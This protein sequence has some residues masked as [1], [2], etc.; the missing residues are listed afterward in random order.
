MSGKSQKSGAPQLALA[1]FSSLVLS[2]ALFLVPV[3][4][5]HAQSTVNRAPSFDA[6]QTTIT[7]VENTP[8]GTAVGAPVAATDPDGD[9]LYFALTNG[10]TDL[11]SI[12]SG[13]GQLRTT[14]PLDYETRP[15]DGYWVHVGVRDGRG[16]D[17]SRDLVADDVGLV[18]VEVQNVDEPGTVTL[19][20]KKPQIGAPL[21]ATL[22]DQD[23]E[24]SGL[25]WQWA[26]SASSGAYTD[27]NGATS[28]TYTPVAGNVNRHLRV[29][30][31]YADP[32]GSGKTAQT[33]TGPVLPAP[34][35]DNAPVFSEGDS[36][37][38]SVT[39]NTPPNSNVGSPVKATNTDNQELRY[40]LD[41]E[42]F[43]IDSRTG[44]IKTKTSP[45][46]ET[47]QS[48]TVQV[49]VTDPFA[50]SDSISVTINVIDQPVEIVGPSNV[51]YSEDPYSIAAPV[52]QYT[53]E[54]SSA[55]LT[56]TGPDAR[57]FSVTASWGLTFNEQPDY[58][59]P[60]DTGRNNVYDITINAVN[61][62]HRMT[63]NVRVRVT[64]Y[65]EAPAITGPEVVE[66]A[67]QTTGAVARY[68][69]RDPENDPIRWEVQDTDDWSY[70]QIS[71]SGVLA[72]REP[73]DF[74]T[75]EKD[76]YEVVI[77]AQSG[78]NAA[79]DGKRI[80]VI[81]TD[82]ADP[83]FFTRGY[84]LPRE[85]SENTAP[86]SPVGSPVSATG[87]PGM[88][89]TYTL[90]GADARHFT[91]DSANG[92]LKTKSPL[93]YEARN[94][95]AVT[96]RASDGKLATDAAITINI[97]NEDEEG[98]VT[99]STNSPRARI[100]L[101]ARLTDPDGGVT[102]LTWQWA[103]STDQS[104]WT[105]I[106]GATS[107]T[108]SPEDSDVNRYLQATAYYTDAQGVSKS[109]EGQS[110]SAV[111]A[112]PN[113]S[114][115][116]RQTGTTITRTVAENSGADTEIGDPVTAVDPDG[117]TLTY[118]LV[119]G[120]ASSFSIVAASGQLKT[121]A[122]LNYERKNSYTVVVRA[123]DSSNSY[124]NITVNISVT[125]VDEEGT[126]TLSTTQPRVGAAVT[127]ILNDP[128]GGR[129]NTA[130]QWKRADTATGAGS[131]ISG[132]TGGSYTPVSGDLGKDLW[133]TV[134]Y[135]DKHGSGKTV[136]SSRSSVGAAR[137]PRNTGGGSNN[138][139]NNGGGDLNQLPNSVSK[140][141]VN[142][143][144]S[145]SFGS[146]NYRVNEGG[147]VQVTVRLPAR[148][149]RALRV[150]VTVRRGTAEIGDYRVSGLSAGELYFSQGSRTR[151]F[152]ITALQDDDRQDETLILG[153][154]TL[155]Q[156]ISL[157][158]TSRA[159]VTIQDDDVATLTVSY[160]SA[161][162]RVNEGGSTQVTVTLSAGAPSTL[163][164][165]VTVRRG[166]AE[167]G[168]YRVSGLSGAAL[169]FGQGS[170]SRSFVITA[171]QDEDADD[172][173]VNLGFGTLSNTVT[174]G[175]SNRAVLT[176]NDDEVP[177]PQ[178]LSVDF[179][180]AKYAVTEGRSISITVRASAG[181]N[182]SLEI[183]IIADTQSSGGGN[184]VL[185][186]LTGGALKLARGER[187]RSF[188]FTAL[189]DEDTE[190]EQVRLRFGTLPAN[191][192]EGSRAT[193]TVTI[194]DDDVAPATVK[195]VNRPPLFTEGERT[196]RTVPEQ[197]SRGTPVGLPVTAL[198]PDGDTLTYLLAG[199]DASLFS[200]DPR[201]G[202][203]Q[204]WGLLDLESKSTYMLN[205]SVSDGRGGTDSIMVAV[206]LS[207]IQEVPVE[208]PSTQAV[209]LVTGEE[210][211]YLETP[212]GT[213][214]VSF[215]A[216]YRELPFFVL[217]ESDAVTCGGGPPAGTA[218]A[219]VTVRLHDSW[220]NIIRNAEM[221]GAVAS[222]RFDA[223]VLGGA[224]AA[225]SAHENGEI[226]VYGYLETEGDWRTH[227]FT[228]QV[229][230]LGVLTLTAG[231]LSGPTCLVA[232]SNHPTSVQTSSS[233]GPTLE[234]EA[235]QKVVWGSYQGERF[236]SSEGEPTDSSLPVVDVGG[237]GGSAD[238]A[239][240]AAGP[241]VVESGM[242][243]NIPWWPRLF[244][245]IGAILLLGALTWQLS[246]FIKEK[247]RLS[248]S[249]TRP[250]NSLWRDILRA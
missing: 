38:R 49:T 149:V 17:G 58:E 41:H 34:Q 35:I 141:V 128:D 29:T 237:N 202:Q 248:K 104:N 9:P 18:V 120:N 191:V 32:A 114:P 71:Q 27:I 179:R 42:H 97:I 78:M 230:E 79:T 90:R 241:A 229:D 200:L 8:A 95:Y 77:I 1:I 19:S 244:L 184:Y 86:D 69:A 150:P 48:H 59:A 164:V 166:T 26:E 126:V 110:T 31:T 119:G 89:L 246:Q 215:P 195:S 157:G 183:P 39:E 138:P 124:V 178:Q 76:A 66:F 101:T 194:E 115:A 55:T 133:A 11:F 47:A 73:P 46:Y 220:G 249:F 219:Y 5:V 65:N 74:E 245:V 70:F 63:K 67:E 54:P 106:F 13:T 165:P 188:T 207:D 238:G 233:A 228:L 15:E 211:F 217:V 158:S 24:P 43:S 206:N 159:T 98:S 36:T 82:G 143:A 212:D 4:L 6:F 177:P 51:D 87:G 116:L 108:F 62:D 201:T 105:D 16:P 121:K 57:L 136:H 193:G 131:D 75:R 85:I 236:E 205:V 123:G 33:T 84:S 180:S 145:V 185:S 118:T 192:V 162:Y 107:Q 81:V 186:G 152:V 50:D 197:A 226:Q 117:D 174:A 83:P 173:T 23:G 175:S 222:L 14:A 25:S 240:T 203:L 190:D 60:R 225:Y 130:W 44:Q 231:D 113:R 100:P 94:R 142:Q 172:E 204:V 247:R 20:W 7:V 146:T 156:G 45:D 139:G 102:A 22:A 88:T 37:T 64:N 30:V 153:F 56:L 221:E 163:R 80:R 218:R 223:Q 155:P 132:A 129:S 242:V 3:D 111:S 53:I 96:V 61:G 144:V 227:D 169:H 170:R 91:I 214:A 148:A 134:T 213:A 140:A 127:A 154:G 189:D 68:T 28:A 40:S 12:D 235:R 171:L 250:R 239:V 182:R 137:V 99:L 103:S 92:Q 2:A 196:G 187:S 209:G 72:F 234:P 122:G 10:H 224:E 243:G 216:G 176:I 167:S 52:A 210:P 232:V 208:N 109:A 93:N 161:G 160:S 125:D 181:S 21:K 151:S 112:G 147:S 199:I 168:D 198:D 135:D